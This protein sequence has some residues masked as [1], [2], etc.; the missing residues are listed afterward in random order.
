MQKK[1]NFILHAGLIA[2]Y[3]AWLFSSA[4]RNIVRNSRKVKWVAGHSI[5]SVILD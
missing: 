3:F 4:W 1:A 5:K 2:N